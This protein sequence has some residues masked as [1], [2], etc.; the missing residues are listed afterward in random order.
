MTRGY[1]DSQGSVVSYVPVD[2]L[3]DPESESVLPEP[4]EFQVVERHS[5]LKIQPIQQHD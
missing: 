3:E 1:V 4:E 5:S 2:K